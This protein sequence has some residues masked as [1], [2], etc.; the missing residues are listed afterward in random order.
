MA[1]ICLECGKELKDRRA[2][3][4][5]L[6]GVHGRRTGLRVELRMAM[7]DAAAAREMALDHSERLAHFLGEVDKR[8]DRFERILSLIKW[9]ERDQ[10][11][12]MD[13]DG[14]RAWHDF[15]QES[16]DEK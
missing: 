13:G 8:L 14:R 12:T 4:G 1:E 5:H 2:L 9:R 15:L 7:S 16:R 3:A 10:C 11:L 6:Y